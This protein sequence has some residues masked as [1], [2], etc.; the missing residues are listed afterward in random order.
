MPKPY[1]LMMSPTKEEKSKTFQL[2]KIQTR[3]LVASFEGLNSYP[4]QS[5][6]K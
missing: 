4:A 2:N 1:Q 3:R 6:G 5:S